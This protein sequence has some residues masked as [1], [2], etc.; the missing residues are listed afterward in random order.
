M[1]NENR[2]FSPFLLHCFQNA[3]LLCCHILQIHALQ[4]VKS[5]PQ[6]CVQWGNQCCLCFTPLSYNVV[7]WWIYYSFLHLVLSKQLSKKTSSNSVEQRTETLQ[8]QLWLQGG[9]CRQ[10]PSNLLADTGSEGCCQ[11][12]GVLLGLFGL[13][14]TGRGSQVLAGQTE[15]SSGGY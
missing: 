11:A 10:K 9:W 7:F 1:E 3:I 2:K 8:L 12:E 5:I 4:T 15:C 14:D 13:W 6:M